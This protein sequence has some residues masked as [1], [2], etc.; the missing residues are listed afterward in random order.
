VNCDDGPSVAT[1]FIV[2]W[3]RGS[4]PELPTPNLPGCEKPQQTKTIPNGSL[5]HGFIETATIRRYR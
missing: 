5:V 1:N 4:H 2:P 3:P